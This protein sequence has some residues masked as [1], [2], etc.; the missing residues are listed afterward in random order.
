[1][2][3]IN[4]PCPA[5]FRIPTQAEWE[6]EIQTWSSRTAMG[7]FASPLKLPSAGFRQYNG[8][9]NNDGAWADYWTSTVSQTQVFIMNFNSG[10]AATTNAFPRVWGFSCRCIKN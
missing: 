2:N 5:G 9:L 4:N 1:V 3:G 6:A 8:A 7:A 10:G